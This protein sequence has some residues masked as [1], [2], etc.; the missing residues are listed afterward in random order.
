MLHGEPAW[1]KD[2]EIDAVDSRCVGNGLQHQKDR[3]IRM[4]EADRA[5][6]VEAAKIVLVWRQIAAPGD[7]IEG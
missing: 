3:W 5:D 4:V 2:H 6:G 7:D 1:R